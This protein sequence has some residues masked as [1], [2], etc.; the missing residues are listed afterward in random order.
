MYKYIYIY[1]MYI[2]ILYIYICIYIYIYIYLYTYCR[3][4]TKRIFKTLA[5]IT[6][7]L[8]PKIPFQSI[9]KKTEKKD[10]SM[11]GKM[12]KKQ[13]YL[14]FLSR[15]FSVKMWY[16]LESICDAIIIRRNRE[17]LE[18]LIFDLYYI[19]TGISKSFIAG[20]SLVNKM[21][22][23]A[24]SR[25][26]WNKCSLIVGRALGMRQHFYVVLRFSSNT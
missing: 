5:I 20:I 18:N 17:S 15:I 26:F 4:F 6:F 7:W 9:F 25:F 14:E 13:E 3:L 22:I 12:K 24:F 11:I 1:Y 10:S 2:Y 21:I 23:N 8:L 16:V 19:C